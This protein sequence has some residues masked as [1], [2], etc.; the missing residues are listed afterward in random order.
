M[1]V[2]KRNILIFWQ[3]LL[4]GV[5]LVFCGTVIINEKLPKLN[6]KK[7]EEKIN[8][9][10]NE[11]YSNLD[12]R[13]GKFKYNENDNSY[14]ITYYDKDFK[15]LNF[16][17]K[18]KNNKISDNY[19][20]NFVRGKTVIDNAKKKVLKQYNKVFENTNY[21]KIKVKFNDLDKYTEDEQA[22]ILNNNIY[23]TGYYSVSYY[24]KVDS[25][26]TVYLN[27]LINSFK[28]IALNNGLKARNYSITFD[29]NGIIKLVEI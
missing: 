2:K 26:D 27:N 3:A 9:Y 1:S 21:E 20:S 14:S 7:E 28:M 8:N 19:K 18:S 15:N 29:N 12:V 11:N 5:I 10:Y 23:N 13:K 16:T 25:L 4:L 22:D 6:A 17:I 24:V